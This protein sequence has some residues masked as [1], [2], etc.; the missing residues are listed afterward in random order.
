MIN[1]E[2]I[3]FVIQRYK[4]DSASVYN[5]WFKPASGA[6]QK[7]FST[8][9]IGVKEVVKDIKDGVFPNDFKESSLERVLT[10]ITE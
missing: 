9:R 4:D 8:I 7:A 5:T 3:Q 2:K 10:V 6:R 1:R